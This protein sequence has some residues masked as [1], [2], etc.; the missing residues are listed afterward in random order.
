M[1]DP[2]HNTVEAVI[3]S[4]PKLNFIGVQWHAELLQQKSDT[5]VQLFSFFINTY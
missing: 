5:D 3:S 2:R 4:N 1:S